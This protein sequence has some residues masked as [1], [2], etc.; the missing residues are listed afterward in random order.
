MSTTTNLIQKYYDSFNQGNMAGMF[1]CLHPDFVHDVN[2]GKRQGGLVEFTK[3]MD[4]M[5]TCYKEELKD[6]YI[7]PHVS[8][9]RASAEFVVHGTYLKTDGKLPEAKN[10]KYVIP[11]GTFFEIKDDKILRVTTYYNLNDW[12][13]QVS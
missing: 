13:K 8:G 7:M 11:A 3:F 5:N 12:I 10:Q 9:K 2:E 4:H 6:I 1:S